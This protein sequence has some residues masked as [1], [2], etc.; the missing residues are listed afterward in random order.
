[1]PVERISPPQINSTSAPKRK[2]KRTQHS[3][4]LREG[5]RTW[6]T[7][8]R[9]DLFQMMIKGKNVVRWSYRVESKPPSTSMRK[10]TNHSLWIREETFNSALLT[11]LWG[12]TY[13]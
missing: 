4:M 2:T 1:V 6:S 8:D 5:S 13:H 7:F 12:I 10:H 11:S 3:Q 9:F